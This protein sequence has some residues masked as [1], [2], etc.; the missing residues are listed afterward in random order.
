MPRFSNEQRG[1]GDY[2]VVPPGMYQVSYHSL[3]EDWRERDNGASYAWA[4][5]EIVDAA[6]EANM[7]MVGEAARVFFDRLGQTR[8]MR[9]A[10]DRYWG[11]QYPRSSSLAALLARWGLSTQG[12]PDELRALDEV[13]VQASKDK[14]IWI[15]VRGSGDSTFGI[16]NPA[17]K[18]GM[19]LAVFA[20]FQFRDKDGN[21]T[22]SVEER[23][24]NYGSGLNRLA[25]P[26]FRIVHPAELRDSLHNILFVNYIVGAEFEDDEWLI[27]AGGDR[28][29]FP[30]LCACIGV[31]LEDLIDAYAT[32]I[33]RMCYEL[34]EDN[35]GWG[36]RVTPNF[37]PL[38]EQE[39]LKL[40]QA[41]TPHVLKL[42][43]SEKG[44]V[45]DVQVASAAEVTKAMGSTSFSVLPLRP[46]TPAAP[47]DTGWTKKSYAEAV[48]ETAGFTVFTNGEMTTRGIAW[49]K[50]YMAPMYTVGGEGK[51][52]YSPA[53]PL[54]VPPEVM[55]QIVKVLSDEGY[56]EMCGDAPKTSKGTTQY[57]MVKD[58]I[59]SILAEDE[60]AEGGFA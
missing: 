1:G 26:L 57:E 9:D 22:W 40:A 45:K 21:P 42:T 3:S 18:K 32:D 35:E 48:N 24:G 14:P 7:A 27:S 59:E 20:G 36:G 51:F 38:I 2:T 4:S 25:S 46:I 8:P 12:A 17:P 39:G 16:P 50:I 10:K 58:L 19:T 49:A 11:E 34:A 23:G 29:K 30:K 47:S 6:D 13:L 33:D 31:P 52:L 37:L 53:K 44:F 55:E 54:E 41:P 56:R 60:A 5:L 43:F 15:E 28:A